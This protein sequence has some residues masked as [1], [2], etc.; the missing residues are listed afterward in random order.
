MPTFDT[1]EPISVAIELAVGHVR[2]VASDRADTVVDVRPSDDSDE[3]DV[4]AARQVRVEYANGTL[5]VKAPKIRPF[6]FSNKTR[7]VDITIELPS[8][9]RVEG[10]AQLGDLGS[11]GR[12]GELRYKSGTGHIRLDRTGELRVH[13]GAGDVAAEAVDGNADISTGSG[14]VQVG[15][16]T[17]TT[18]AKNS[19]GD[20]SIDHSAAGGEVK[21]SHGRIRVGEV[22]RGAVVAKTAMGDVEVGIAERTAAWLDVHTGYGRVRNSLEAAAEPDASEDTVEV[23]ANTSFGDITIHRS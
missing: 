18:V 13:T 15:E 1:P 19:N 16:V 23:R 5:Q 11:T 9:S 21:T 14:R 2:I 8:G 17:G 7:S 12:L 20:I 4:K 10:S 6:D 22:V 3:S